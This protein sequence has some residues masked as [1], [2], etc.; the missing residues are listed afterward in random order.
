MSALRRFGAVAVVAAMFATTTTVAAADT[1]PT[2]SVV[3]P[4]STAPPSGISSGSPG[5][6]LSVQAKPMFNQAAPGV[7]AVYLVLV[8]NGGATGTSGTP[9]EVAVDGL[10]AGSSVTLSDPVLGAGAAPG[11]TGWRCMG[12]SCAY[13]VAG[14]GGTT[15]PAT[16]AAHAA[17]VLTISVLI[18]PDA[19]PGSFLPRF[20]VGTAGEQRADDN[21]T[22]VPTR[23]AATADVVDGLFVDATG[24]AALVPG[25]TAAVDVRV[26]VT[27]A[28]LPAGLVVRAPLPPGALAWK[29]TT[30]EWRCTEATCVLAHPVA[31]GAWS[32]PLHVEFTAP[33]AGHGVRVVTWKV[34]AVSGSRRG[35]ATIGAEQ[36]PAPPPQ[37]YLNALALGSRN[38]VRAG[39]RAG[40]QVDVVN[41]ARQPERAVVVLLTAPRGF[42]RVDD[43]PAG[44]GCTPTTSTKV[45][46]RTTGA[47]IAANESRSLVV[48]YAV[49]EDVAAGAHVGVRA[50]VPGRGGA[51]LGVARETVPFLLVPPPTTEIH[52]ALFRGTLAAPVRA[53][54]GEPLAAQPSEILEYGFDL[55]ERGERAAPIDGIVHVRQVLPAG[56]LELGHVAVSPGW[57]CATSGRTL[58]CRHRLVEAL[59]PGGHL[60]PLALRARVRRGAKVGVRS[61]PVAV[62]VAGDRHARRFR[63]Q[64]DAKVPSVS[65][66][67]RASVALARVPTAGGRGEVAIHVVN[68]GHGPATTV[69]F[70]A[71]VPKG[72]TLS[73][74]GR[75]GWRCGARA[76]VLRCRRAGPLAV[77]E[78]T[79][80]ARLRLSVPSAD[81]IAVRATVAGS[82]RATRVVVHPR[83]RLTASGQARPKTVVQA[84]ANAKPR[85]V[86]LDAHATTGGGPGRTYLWRQRCTT[87]ADSRR[88]PHVCH[89]V[90]PRVDW[91]EEGNAEGAEAQS[92]TFVPARVT[93]ATTLHFELRVSDDSASASAS[94]SVLVVPPAH[95]RSHFTPHGRKKIR[96]AVRLR[97]RTAAY[98]VVDTSTSSTTAP[99]TTTT[100]T[101]TT[102]TTTTTPSTTAASV[103]TTTA[104]RQPVGAST[105]SGSMA[106]SPSAN[107]DVYQAAATAVAPGATVTLTGAGSGVGALTYAWRQLSGPTATLTGASTQSVAIGTSSQ[108]GA[109]VVQL[110][111]TDSRGQTGTD[112]VTIAVG[113]A[114]STS[115]SAPSTKPAGTTA[116]VDDGGATVLAVAGATMKFTGTGTG[117]APLS[118]AWTQTDGASVLTGVVTNGPTLSFIAPAIG[119][120]VTLDLTV[121]AGD[122]TTAVHTTVVSASAPAAPPTLCDVLGEISA[123]VS[124]TVPTIVIGAVS[125]DLG[126]VT[127]TG[128]VC[129][130]QS[131]VTFSGASLGV[132]GF[133]ITDA[134]GV[135]D[136]SGLQI[137]TGTVTPPADWGIPAFTISSPAGLMAAFSNGTVA[138]LQGTLSAAAVPFLTLP[139][140]WTGSSTLT[141]G[142]AS[143]AESVTLDGTASASGGRTASVTGMVGSDGTFALTATAVGIIQLGP[144]AID[145]SG[146]INRASAGGPVAY[147]LT[148][149]LTAPVAL[150]DGVQL[151]SLV[152]T[153][154][155][156]GV[157]AAGTVVLGTSATTVTL[158]VTATVEDVDDWS[159]AV[160]GGTGALTAASGLV[161]SGS[162]FSGTVASVA[163]ALQVQ[164]AASIAGT[165]APVAGVSFTNLALAGSWRAASGL[166]FSFSGGVVVTSGGVHASGTFAASLAGS[167]FTLDAKLTGLTVGAYTVNAAALHLVSKPTDVSVVVSGSVTAFSTTAAASVSITDAGVLLTLALGTYSL[168]SS[169][170]AL[171]SAT[172][173]YSTYDTQF[174]P[175]VPG[176]SAV[177]VK[178]E[179]AQLIGV[180]TTP[181]WFNNAL[182]LTTGLTGTAVA[183]V[184][185]DTEAFTLEVSFSGSDYWLVQSTSGTTVQLQ[186]ITF[187]ISDAGGNASMSVGAGAVMSV[188]SATEGGP[189]SQ[190]QLDAD[191]AFNAKTQDL[192]ASLTAVGAWND[193][194]GVTGLTLKDLAVT[195]GIDFSDAVPLPEMGVNAT[196]ILPNDVSSKLGITSGTPI[197]VAADIGVGQPCL[198]IDIG[199]TTGKG[200]VLSIGAGLVTA[201]YAHLLIAP[202]GCTIGTTTYA[203][204]LAV[205]FD[206]S[207]AGTPVTVNAELDTDPF[208][209]KAHLKVGAF[210]VGPLTVDTTTIDLDVTDASF[211]LQ[212]QGAVSVLGTTVTVSG[213]FGT[214]PHGITA[215]FHGTITDVSLGPVSIPTATVSFTL[216]DGNIDV[217]VDGTVDVFGVAFK[218]ALELDVVAGQ[219]ESFKGSVTGDIAIGSLTLKQAKVK[220]DYERASSAISVTVGADLS[221]GG[222]DGMKVAGTVSNNGIS[223][224][225]SFASKG[226]VSL[227]AAVSGSIVWAT[228]GK[229]TPTM[230]NHSGKTVNA[231]PGDFSFSATNVRFTLP[232]FEL[233]GSLAFGHVGTDAW[234]SV[235]ATLA[236]PIDNAAI[237]VA[238]DIDSSGQFSFSGSATITLVGFAGSGTF[239]LSNKAGFHLAA[240]LVL[241]VA[242]QNVN[243]SGEFDQDNGS[244][245]YSLTGS[246]TLGMGSF[247]G[248]GSFSLSNEPGSAG[249]SAALTLHASSYVNV[250]GT[251]AYKPDGLYYLSAT[252]S[253]VVP[254]VT[255]KGTFTLTNCSSPSCATGTGNTLLTFA[256]STML[257]GFSFTISGAID[258]NGGFSLTAASPA[259][260]TYSGGGTV[261]LAV[262]RVSGTVT[263][264]MSA[265]LSSAPPF[266]AVSGSGSASMAYQYYAPFSW[267]SWHSLGQVAAGLQ[268]SP[269]KVWVSLDVAGQAVTVTF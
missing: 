67:L 26:L 25:T 210:P 107:A 132:G 170:P 193:A 266:L 125:V 180:F 249:M 39:E 186:T 76:R 260:G 238:G 175:Q 168:G 44:W 46:C 117:L 232:A 247:T 164:V 140:G 75:N 89:G 121:T 250:S 201:T 115:M 243:F 98:Q 153:L 86:T 126:R 54:D 181:A 178:K 91:I 9:V 62:T 27:G 15:A 174:T 267:S 103:T 254:A 167:T 49:G 230:V 144:A 16:I 105:Q 220:F 66:K 116:D 204:G 169:V 173:A 217:A 12:A 241:A 71:V 34:Q 79:P 77:G 24:P 99:A 239:S 235:A 31:T 94:T 81:A 73:H 14:P 29:V 83:A 226:S 19:R 129:G 32:P 59:A 192:S 13:L 134:A 68:L 41:Q 206:G 3:P 245:H 35:E 177:S 109:I 268:T 10:P 223:I 179:T 7:A 70:T 138:G 196:V 187:S 218:P 248:A 160:T 209:I 157:T 219:I 215:D 56:L 90:V 135:I 216:D 194:F 136:A 234:V 22:A 40:V 5:V 69:A 154:S 208:A 6:D 165:W 137:T 42:T 258:S 37:L 261:N 152:A 207:V 124:A 269:F 259:T 265:T 148:G 118:Y 197:T 183:T 161:V 53:G 242:G 262:L 64:V 141:F 162:A 255:V 97:Y 33:A 65:P 130:A 111:V 199:T 184:D 221:V 88:A 57:R 227:S 236:L 18:A 191:I 96:S 108:S 256:A 176:L 131:S 72:T 139:S 240:S 251:L 1:D 151:A 80:L 123:S 50:S 159:L 23:I 20:T 60:P 93:K 172:L 95:G 4:S 85:T 150:G 155:Q 214:G 237:A 30:P 58:D 110:A 229:S 84:A 47:P 224:S 149:L 198:N 189:P 113:A 21:A 200:T 17:T 128:G 185:T 28:P 182:S 246:A 11:A 244:V 61:W 51:T 146:S 2:V 120:Q 78:R 264:A 190:T 212:F 36:R 195:V 101:K 52:A 211:S 45:L 222:Y 100:T 38:Q 163:G 188:P 145:A 158:G 203:P 112:Q 233:T 147:S 92:A 231:S 74:I 122:G 213:G 166:G 143:G 202:K 228:S 114:T 102:T 127:V 252:G 253:L 205:D 8:S 257:S 225:G 87:V 171:T 82:R 106:G 104:A 55:V 142:S 156:K 63:L 133:T 263:Y 48:R 119:T 43:R